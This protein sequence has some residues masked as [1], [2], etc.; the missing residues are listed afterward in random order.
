MPLRRHDPFIDPTTTRNVQTNPFVG[1]LASNP[2]VCLFGDRLK[3]AA[4]NWRNEFSD[5]SESLSESLSGSL[6]ES[7]SES[8]SKN[9]NT[10]L[11]VEIGC[12]KGRTLL[13]L[14]QDNPDKLFL[15]F[16]IT[17]KRIV[18]CSTRIC[19]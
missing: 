14:A 13:E 3:N 5:M 2:E 6:S 7:L 18:T 8:L 12:Y 16:D 10:K 11:I 4:G 9:E 1:Q 17:F 15:G 19:K